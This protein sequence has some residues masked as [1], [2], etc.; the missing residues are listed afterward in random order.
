MRP[1][2]RELLSSLAHQGAA[3]ASPDALFVI[4]PKKEEIAVKR[5]QLGI[6]V[7][8][9]VDT[10]CARTGSTTRSRAT[11]TRSA[12]SASSAPRSPRR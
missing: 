4:D 10:N 11:T 5:Q 8:A 1:R 7:V 2:A 9:V 3:Q 12:P 6:P